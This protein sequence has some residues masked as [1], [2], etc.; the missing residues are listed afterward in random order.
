MNFSASLR[1][2]LAQ[3]AGAPAGS[4]KRRRAPDHESDPTGDGDGDGDG[5]NVGSARRVR[6]RRDEPSSVDATNEAAAAAA[7]PNNA[8]GARSDAAGAPTDDEQT[9]ADESRTKVCESLDKFARGAIDKY[10]GGLVDGGARHHTC[11][12]CDTVVRYENDVRRMGGDEAGVLVEGAIGYKLAIDYHNNHPNMPLRQKAA[13]LTEIY[14]RHVYDPA[15]RANRGRAPRDLP[16]PNLAD[17]IEH[18][19]LYNF[20]PVAI[21]MEA[22]QQLRHLTYTLADS[23]VV[24]G[25]ADLAVSRML[26][27]TIAAMLR[28]S[29]KQVKMLGGKVS[30]PFALDAQKLMTVAGTRPLELFRAQAANVLGGATATNSNDALGMVTARRPNMGALDSVAEPSAEGEG[31]TDSA[32]GHDAEAA[33][34]EEEEARDARA[35]APSGA[36][37]AA[38]ALPRPPH[39]PVSADVSD[40]ADDALE[41]LFGATDT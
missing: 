14:R 38:A 8:W 26:V 25:R 10:I 32:D 12:F 41:A 39:S 13:G 40:D 6:A 11:F 21:N 23:V 37:P 3:Q 5:D 9:T 18:L 30:T 33:D 4:R 24:D 31:D 35:R 34:E 27:T 7:A 2:S 29:D 1:A 17:M 20:D 15:T 28:V 19:L 22:F 16:P 36:A